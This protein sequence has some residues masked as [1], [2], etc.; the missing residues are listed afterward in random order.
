MEWSRPP[1]RQRPARAKRADAP[2]AIHCSLPRRG[3]AMRLATSVTALR[4]APVAPSASRATVPKRLGP[5]LSASG[6]QTVAAPSQM[7]MG[8][9]RSAGA[10]ACSSPSASALSGFP[11]RTVA[12][13]A[14]SVPLA[15]S[16]ALAL[17]P[18]GS[19]SGGRARVSVPLCRGLSSPLAGPAVVAC[20]PCAAAGG[21]LFSLARSARARCARPAP[22]AETAGMVAACPARFHTRW[23][24]PLRAGHRFAEGSGPL[25][26]GG[27]VCRRPGRAPW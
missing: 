24:V 12:T 14:F 11:S 7:L 22:R 4:C 21:V 15:L 10:R 23:G 5:R 13:A 8:T 26:P 6:T 27:A 1:L 19:C 20:S 3:S 16:A 9:T 2:V 17:A 25:R 18:C